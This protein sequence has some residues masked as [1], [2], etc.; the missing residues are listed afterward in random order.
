M[1]FSFFASKIHICT[2]TGLQVVFFRFRKITFSS[3]NLMFPFLAQGLHELMFQQEQNKEK[4]ANWPIKMYSEWM[5]RAFSF[6][7]SFTIGVES[8]RKTVLFTV[9]VIVPAILNVGQFTMRLFLYLVETLSG[10]TILTSSY[11][12]TFLSD[13]G[14]KLNNIRYKIFCRIHF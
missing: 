6:F 12:Q 7:F 3:I 1:P 5:Q 14:Q 11:F 2:H 9:W 8:R 10:L 4:Y 13:Q